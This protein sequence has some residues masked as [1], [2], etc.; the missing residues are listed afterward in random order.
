M[1]VMVTEKLDWGIGMEISDRQLAI[2]DCVLR[3]RIGFWAFG[4]R[5]SIGKLEL[6]LGIKIGIGMEDRD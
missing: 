1:S 5:F 2:G 6:G 4:M 3:W